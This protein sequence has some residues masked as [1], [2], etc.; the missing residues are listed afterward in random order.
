FEQHAEGIAEVFG[1]FLQGLDASPRVA[2]HQAAS[3]PGEIGDKLARKLIV[4]PTARDGGIV[5]VAVG[6]DEDLQTN[7]YLAGVF[8]CRAQ[9]GNW[10]PALWSQDF[11]RAVINPA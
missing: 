9:E 3:V 2:K 11:F 7:C 6:S 5:F 10:P 4:Q 1:K 8:S